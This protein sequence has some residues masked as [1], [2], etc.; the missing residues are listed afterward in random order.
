M[1]RIHEN[2]VNKIA[3][4]NLLHII[5]NPSK[6]TKNLNIHYS[7]ILHGYRNARKD[8]AKFNNFR[9][10]LGSGWIYFHDLNEKD[11]NKT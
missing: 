10:L 9:V 5:I 8:R 7:H 4:C 3:E 6:R 11:N 2:K 1:N